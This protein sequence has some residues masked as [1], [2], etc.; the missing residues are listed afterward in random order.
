MILK[1]TLADHVGPFETYELAVSNAR[2]GD[3]G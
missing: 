1:L 3:F 2:Y